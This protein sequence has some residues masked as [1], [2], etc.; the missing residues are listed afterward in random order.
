MTDEHG[1]RPP[2][3]VEHCDHVIDRLAIVNGPAERRGLEA[4]LLK[5]RDAKTGAEL[6]GEAV[7]VLVAQAGAAVQQQYG[8]AIADDPAAER[9]PGCL[10]GER[11]TLT[12]RGEAYSSSG[13]AP[14]V[15]SP[16]LVASAPLVAPT[17]ASGHRRPPP[18]AL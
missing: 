10:H 3:A 18:R 8:S 7:E 11:L 4:A 6:V 12:H 2:Q 16:P 17:D 9:A 15:M 1:L 13:S 14:L 5:A